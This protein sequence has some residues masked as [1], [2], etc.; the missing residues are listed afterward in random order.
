MY[1]RDRDYWRIARL[2]ASVTDTPGTILDL[3]ASLY[4]L[5]ERLIMKKGLHTLALE[6]D[7]FDAIT[8]DMIAACEHIDELLT[9]LDEKLPEYISHTIIL[10]VATDCWNEYW[11]ANK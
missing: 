1:S 5:T 10:E 2:T 6:Q 9:Q 3:T 7:V 11:T 4:E 8:T